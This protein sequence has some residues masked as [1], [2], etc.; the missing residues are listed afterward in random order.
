VGIRKLR[1]GKLKRYVKL[2]YPILERVAQKGGTING[3]EIQTDGGLI[4]YKDLL[5]EMGGAPGRGFIGDVLD[6]INEVENDKNCPK[7]S[8]VV[9]TAKRFTVSGGFFR[10]PN[11]PAR[12]KRSRKQGRDPYLNDAEEKQ[13]LKDLKEVW[14]RWAGTKS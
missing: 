4:T 3:A 14:D 9:V 5:D 6:R 8:A 2:A 13:W 1:P 12:V 10:S 11:T 7:L